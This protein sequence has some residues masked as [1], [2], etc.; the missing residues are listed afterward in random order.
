MRRQRGLDS[1]EEPR[2]KERN[3]VRQTLKEIEG[4]TEIR[5]R[6]R[7]GGWGGGA[8]SGGR[9]MTSVGGRNERKGGRVRW[10]V[11]RVRKVAEG[12]GTKGS[13]A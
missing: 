13:K 5:S 7:A 10:R 3:Q 1:G 12:G 9:E 2:D 11:K 4:M 8:T 6:R